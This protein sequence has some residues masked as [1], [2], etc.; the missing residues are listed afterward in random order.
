M[1]LLVVGWYGTETIGDRAILVGILS[2]ISNVVPISN[3]YIG[4][5]NPFFTERSILEDKKFISQVGCKD[6]EI[7]VI[8][9]KSK[10]ELNNYINKSDLIIMG[11][12]PI[13]SILD[14]KMIDYV[15]SF[16]KKIGK[17]TALMGCGFDPLLS[18]FYK[19]IGVNI[20]KNSDIKI[21]RDR[22]AKRNATSL[23]DERAEQYDSSEYKVSIDPAVEA[24]LQYNKINS[25]FINKENEVVVNFRDLP[26]I[27]NEFGKKD[28]IINYIHKFIADF[29]RKND[30][31]LIRL[32]PM[33]YFRDGNDDRDFL[34][35]IK[36][37]L[38][39]I[40]NIIVQNEVLTLEQTLKCFSS[41]S[42][43]IG[44]RFHSVVLM[45][46][47]N[48]NNYILDYTNP[49]KGKIIGFLKDI[50]SEELDFYASR[51]VNL[52]ELN[53]NSNSTWSIN[54]ELSFKYD[55]EAIEKCLMVYDNEIKR[56]FY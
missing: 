1:K 6:S 39:D 24:A 44:M 30:N 41:A 12:G 8:N 27:Y 5:L 15:F 35:D 11:G 46:I 43:S 29:A 31:I 4:A 52:H 36:F 47:L 37:S 32:V 45:T 54:D 55:I 38:P 13:M 33:H 14:L 21:F 50:D 22:T 56:F 9:S 19:K 34:N 42:A 16:A 40:N 7:T 10:S 2:R 48:K 17:K 3:I 25:D 18:D 26:E 51:Y 53:D 20:L 28:I 49:K 23:M